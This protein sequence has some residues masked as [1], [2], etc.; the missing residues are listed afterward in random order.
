MD[1]ADFLKVT[2]AMVMTA[3]RGGL[4][5]D[6]E[7]RVLERAY[8]MYIGGVSDDQCRNYFEALRIELR[9]LMSSTGWNQHS[10]CRTFVTCHLKSICPKNWWTQFF[11]GDQ[12]SKGRVGGVLLKRHQTIDGWVFSPQIPRLKASA[13]FKMRR[14]R[15]WKTRARWQLDGWDSYDIENTLEGRF[16]QIFV[17]WNH[18]QKKVQDE[19]SHET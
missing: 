9:L 15:T 19:R 2:D 8:F 1:T 12:S 10:I 5:P 14:F 13:A 17:R 4:T 3:Q 11:L 7:K 18:F 16:S 6:L